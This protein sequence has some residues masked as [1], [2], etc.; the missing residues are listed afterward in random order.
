MQPPGRVS[1]GAVRGAE[2]GHLESGV[3]R[4]PGNPVPTTITAPTPDLVEVERICAIENRVL[5][6]LEITDCYARLSQTLRSRTGPWANWCTFATWASRQAGCTI[7]GEDLI[8]NVKRRLG[9]RA[10]L[11]AP[12]ESFG[13]VLLRKGLFES[14]TRLGRA[15]AEIHTP[16]DGVERASEAVARGNLKVFEEIGREFARYLSMVPEDAPVSSPSFDAFLAGL[17]R[18]EPPEG[19]DLLR[20]AFTH[21][22]SQRQEQ[23]PAARAALVLLAN[24]RIGLHEQTR[25]QPDIA[26]AVDAPVVT[27][28]ELGRRVLH[29]LVPGSRAWPSVL[30]GPVAV[31]LGL[32]AKRIRAV[33]IRVTREAVTEAL[34]VLALPGAVLSLGRDLDAPVPPVLTETSHPQLDA[35]V[36]EHDPCPPGG[37]RCGAEDWCD[38]RQRVHY[39]LHLFRAYAGAEALFSDPFTPEQV[40][41]FR[42]GCIPDGDL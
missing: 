16:F 19:Q 9:R 23:A 37:T 12:V 17:R 28:A 4:L 30:H 29:V 10:R 14:G 24:L 33:G 36:A 3:L 13:R 7:R 8:E 1:R 34:M 6:N 5:R 42:A 27:A 25:L 35:F 32:A 31:A 22:H 40:A 38:L 39:I 41:R 2:A 15:I 20:E 18:G 26:D 11:L 21:Y